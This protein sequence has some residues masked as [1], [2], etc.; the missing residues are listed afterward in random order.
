[1]QRHLQQFAQVKYC[2]LL[3]GTLNDKARAAKVTFTNHEERNNA[4]AAD[5]SKLDGQILRVR[6][7]ACRPKERM[8][9]ARNGSREPICLLAPPGLEPQAHTPK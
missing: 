6:T 1:M 3:S 8:K 7:W 9:E 4:M 5:D 2:A